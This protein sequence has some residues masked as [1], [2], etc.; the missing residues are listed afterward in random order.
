MQTKIRFAFSFIFD[1]ISIMKK[2]DFYSALKKR[3]EKDLKVLK[4]R[5]LSSR[6]GITYISLYRIISDR[7]GG[8]LNN[9]RKIVAYY[10]RGKP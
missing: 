6:I 4:L 2:I 10:E 1:M 7:S 9:W 3:M 8:S 5:E